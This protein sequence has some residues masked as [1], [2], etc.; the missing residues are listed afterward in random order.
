MVQVKAKYDGK[1]LIPDEPLDVPA[2]TDV[3]LTVDVPESTGGREDDDLPPLL[4]SIDPVT[5]K[6]RLGQQR[7]A[8][9]HMSDGFD[10]YL[11]DDFWFGE[12]A[13]KAESG[14]K[15]GTP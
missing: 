14:T 11:G 1:V 10:D 15:D 9:L 13:D 3:R 8:V 2:G 12:D 7:G 5:G 4:P 6:R